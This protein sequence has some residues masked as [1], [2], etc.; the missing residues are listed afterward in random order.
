MR[1]SI[2]RLLL[3]AIPFL[4]CRAVH[5]PEEGTPP[6]PRL[7]SE[8]PRVATSADGVVAVVAADVPGDPVG[9]R[10]PILRF[11]SRTIRELERAFKL[12]GGKQKS[13]GIVIHAQDGTTNDAR[14][15]VRVVNGG[16]LTRIWLPSPGFSRLETLRFEIAKAWFRN[17]VYRARGKAVAE[18]ALLPDWVVQGC[19]RALNA[20]QAH[21]DTRFVL[22]LWSEGRLP[23]FPGLCVHLRTTDG[24]AAAVSGYLVGWMK[25]KRLFRKM[26]DRLA[27]GEPWSGAWL[28]EELTGETDP[29]RQ[30]RVSDERLARLTRAV[31]S[32][33]RASDW[34]V[35]VFT[36]RL[37]LYPP[38]FDKS[39]GANCTSCT[40]SEAIGL[41]AGNE[42][43]RQAAWQ[44]A[45]EM[46]FCAIGRGDGLAA[47]AAAYRKFLVGVARGE[48][49]EVL[50]PLLD[51]ADGL[52]EKMLNEDGKDD[53][54]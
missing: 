29:V 46:P 20:E 7:P 9:F 24:P 37:L 23:F 33:G 25:E 14:V 38:E 15:I 6:P 50:R 42:T 40:F 17:W 27:G 45:R 34:D 54:R 4:P 3:L 49:A 5:A 30:D 22:N 2:P 28:A 41:A 8:M 51:E 43:V 12:E 21:D 13:A 44:K 26:L 11:A 39:I 53:N 47:A 18:E 10:L 19:L 32:P 36:S 31:L 1:M 16:A 52:M 48:S 35:K